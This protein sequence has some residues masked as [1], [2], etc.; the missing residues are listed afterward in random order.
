VLVSLAAQAVG[1][2]GE[3]LGA[4]DEVPGQLGFVQSSGICSTA[5]SMCRCS[6]ASMSA[7]TLRLA[8]ASIIASSRY[9]DR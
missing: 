7:M 5:M 4:G 1:A 9:H 3:Q 8:L 6:L 2:A